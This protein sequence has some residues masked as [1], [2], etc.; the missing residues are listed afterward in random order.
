MSDLIFEF[1]DVAPVKNAVLS[2]SRAIGRV[3]TANLHAA[4]YDAQFIIGDEAVSNDAL[5][6][7][8]CKQWEKNAFAPVWTFYTR[9]KC[10]EKFENTADAAEICAEPFELS[11]Y[12]HENTF[13]RKK[14][15]EV[16]AAACEKLLVATCGMNNYSDVL[17]KNGAS[18]KV[19][20]E[21]KFVA[22]EKKCC[23]SAAAH[24]YID[25]ENV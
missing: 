7:T 18:V 10:A 5:C 16:T 19:V 9:E 4:N 11:A 20:G 14:H 15:G 22:S 1:A 3:A 6:I 13:T 17:Y 21:K 8:E 23:V 12:A 2:V 25:D 24:V